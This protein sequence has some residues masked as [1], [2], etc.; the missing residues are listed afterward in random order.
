M[1]AD[2][3]AVVDWAAVAWVRVVAAA[4]AGWTAAAW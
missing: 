3:A 2:F 1:M 4:A